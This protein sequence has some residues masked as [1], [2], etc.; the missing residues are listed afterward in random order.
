MYQAALRVIH[1]RRAKVTWGYSLND[2]VCDAMESFITANYPDLIEHP[3]LSD[4]SMPAY[5]LALPDDEPDYVP[6]AQPPAERPSPL[7]GPTV[8]P[9]AMAEIQ[10]LPEPPPDWKPRTNWAVEWPQIK[11]AMLTGLS[12]EQATRLKLLF[13]TGPSSMMRKYRT[14]RDQVGYLKKRFPYG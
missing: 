14:T 10:A 13:P 4:D 3:T 11:A 5:M 8:P 12:P 7:L 2:L 1:Q 9:E 6:P